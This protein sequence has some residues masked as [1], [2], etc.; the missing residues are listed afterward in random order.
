MTKTATQEAAGGKS[1][2]GW[3]GF[4]EGLWQRDINLRDFIQRNYE[5]YLGDAS[6]LASATE[7]TK[8]IWNR[9]NELFLVERRKAFSMSPIPRPYRHGPG[10]SI[11]KMKSS[12]DCRPKRR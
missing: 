4:Q 1:M 11:A 6:F 3:E 10:T 2:V 8:K 9:L 7:R 5:E 12:L